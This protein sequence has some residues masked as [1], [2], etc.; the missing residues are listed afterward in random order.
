MD[1]FVGA[2]LVRMSFQVG[3]ACS[4]QQQSI[5]VWT[6]GAPKDGMVTKS[7]VSLYKCSI[8]RK[9]KSLSSKTG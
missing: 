6:A 7:G 3:W 5:M 2:V 4:I 1:C 9:S 8:S